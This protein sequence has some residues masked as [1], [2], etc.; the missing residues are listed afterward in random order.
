[1]E[2]TDPLAT[3]TIFIE[4]VRFELLPLFV[5][6]ARHKRLRILFLKKLKIYGMQLEHSRH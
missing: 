3:R 1:M 4:A 6:Q 2:R 5:A